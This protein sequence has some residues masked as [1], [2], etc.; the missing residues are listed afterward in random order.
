MHGNGVY[1]SSIVSISAGYA[2][3]GTSHNRH[4]Y[5]ARVLTGRYTLGRPKMIVPPKDPNKSDIPF[6]SV[7]NRT[8]HDATT[9]VVFYDS[10]C[11]PEYLITFQ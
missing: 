1:F 5:L 8:G 11:Y 9:F 7:A 10:Q 4:M 2:K 6:D 3:P